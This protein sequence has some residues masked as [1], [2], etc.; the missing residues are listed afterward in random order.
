MRGCIVDSGAGS[1][2]GSGTASS[3]ERVYDVDEQVNGAGGTM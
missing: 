3:E 1:G 2:V